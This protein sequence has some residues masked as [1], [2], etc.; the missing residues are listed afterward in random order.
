[1]HRRNNISAAQWRKQSQELWRKPTTVREPCRC[2]SWDGSRL[3]KVVR[4]AWGD[5]REP[6]QPAEWRPGASLLGAS[7]TERLHHCMGLLADMVQPEYE[8]LAFDSFATRVCGE[9]PSGAHRYHHCAPV[10]A[11]IAVLCGTTLSLDATRGKEQGLLQGDGERDSFEVSLMAMSVGSSLAYR[12]SAHSAPLALFSPVEALW[13]FQNWNLLFQTDGLSDFIWE[14][15]N[16]AQEIAIARTVCPKDKDEPLYHNHTVECLIPAAW[17]EERLVME[18]IAQSWAQECEE[19]T[20]F[21]AVRSGVEPAPSFIGPCAVVDLAEGE[22]VDDPQSYKANSRKLQAVFFHGLRHGKQDWICY[23]DSDVHFIVPNFRRMLVR[24]GLQPEQP[25]WLG[26]TFASDLLLEGLM[27]E[28]FA[29]GCVSR[30]AARQFIETF[31][32][33]DQESVWRWPPALN[34][35][36]KMTIPHP[37]GFTMATANACLRRARIFPADPW[38]SH[39]ARGRL[40]YLNFH[41]LNEGLFE[42]PQIRPPSVPFQVNSASERNYTRYLWHGKEHIYTLCRNE[43]WVGYYPVMFHGHTTR[44]PNYLLQFQGSHKLKKKIK[45]QQLPSHREVYAMLSK[46]DWRLPDDLRA[47]F[48]D[49]LTTPSFTGMLGDKDE[50]GG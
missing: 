28:P 43:R 10:M 50:E 48:S 36:H 35:C 13:N 27:I 30:A 29:G 12:C 8:A 34:P 38:L 20:F 1:M 26:F 19:C 44:D 15:L 33:W 17:P 6:Y 42:N 40:L 21:V 23:A 22:L 25:V 46:L 4:S 5:L 49:V 31:P 47:A 18:E 3:L 14:P 2:P 32:G 11:A 9:R 16:R 39:D 45:M 24:Q 41:P 7:P 37:L